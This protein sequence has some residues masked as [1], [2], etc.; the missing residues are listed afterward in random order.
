MP[1]EKFV[2][3]DITCAF[4]NHVAILRIWI[5]YV[6]NASGAIRVHGLCV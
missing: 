1:L 4:E 5:R 3:T 2:I 6:E